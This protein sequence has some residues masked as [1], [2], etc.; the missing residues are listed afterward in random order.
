GWGRGAWDGE[1]IWAANGSWSSSLLELQSHRRASCHLRVARDSGRRGAGL[2]SN[3]HMRIAA[4]A[5]AIG[6]AVLPPLA[7][8]QDGCGLPNGSRQEWPA[9]ALDIEGLA[10]ATLCPMLQWLDVSKENNV[11]AVLV[12]RH[13]QLGL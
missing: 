12:A 10:G 11:H 13:G 7:S 5:L 6:I 3:Q 1:C 4:L 8:A 9:A 2:R